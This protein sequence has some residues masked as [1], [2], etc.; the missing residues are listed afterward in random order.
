MTLLTSQMPAH[1]HVPNS[2]NNFDSDKTTPAGNIWGASG[3]LDN[4]YASGNPNTT[5]NPAALSIAGSSQP[6]NNMQ[7]TL[8]LNFIICMQGIFPPRG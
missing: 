6:H 4:L 2:A 3:N 7:P 8:T 5:I 1:S